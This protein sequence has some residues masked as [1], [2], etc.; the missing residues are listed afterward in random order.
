MN[1][2]ARDPRP[3]KGTINI[4]EEGGVHAWLCRIA[5]KDCVELSTC[6]VRV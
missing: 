6:S 1:S 2:L 5:V 4:V 3:I